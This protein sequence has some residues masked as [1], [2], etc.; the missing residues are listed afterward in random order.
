V[1]KPT[2]RRGFT[3]GPDAHAISVSTFVAKSALDQGRRFDAMSLR[4]GHRSN[5]NKPSGQFGIHG[6]NRSPRPERGERLQALSKRGPPLTTGAAAMRAHAL[7]RDLPV[8]ISSDT[9]RD[10]VPDHRKIPC[11][12]P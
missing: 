6:R 5:C 4:F 8:P 11:A 7:N 2:R 1:A 10:A 3:V 12:R 9:Q